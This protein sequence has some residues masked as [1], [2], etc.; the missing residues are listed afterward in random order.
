MQ[1]GA[2]E[3]PRPDELTGAVIGACIEVH[4][5]LGPGLLESAYEQWLCHEFMLRGLTFE[6]QRPIPLVYKGLQLD[7]GY[8][9]DLIV[10][11]SLLVEIKAVEHLPLHKAQVITYLELTARRA[12]LLLTLQVSALKQGL[13]R[14]INPKLSSAAPL[15]PVNFLAPV[16]P[17]QR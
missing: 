6:R 8:R 11:Q 9:A 13:R 3:Q 12:G 1:Q 15:L 16:G 10:E 5:H 14:L 17:A 2:A 4:R 7:C